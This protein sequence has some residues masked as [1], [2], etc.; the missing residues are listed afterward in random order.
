MYHSIKKLA[1]LTIVFFIFGTGLTVAGASK[2][3]VEPYNHI[4]KRSTLDIQHGDE[5]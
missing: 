4:L 2:S 3:S 1:G 5:I